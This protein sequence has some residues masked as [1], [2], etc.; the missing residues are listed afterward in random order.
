MI[1]AGYFPKR[2]E[3]TPPTLN[4]P[5]VREIC[6]VSDHISVG[7]NN[8]IERWLHNDFGWFNRIADAIGVIAPG[9]EAQFSLFAYRLLPD[10]FTTDGRVPVAIPENVCP[11]PI[12]DAFQ[13][14]GYDSVNKSM[15]SV[16]GFECSPLSCNLMAAE[17]PANEFCLFPDLKVAIAGAKRFA[18]EQPEP[19]DYFVIEVL[20]RRV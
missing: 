19:G 15:D 17:I 10:K 4:V 3:L 9:Q 7:P 13:S 14:L 20:K 8:W 11:E 12:D 6:S 1:D 2:I 16:L 18:A 5:G